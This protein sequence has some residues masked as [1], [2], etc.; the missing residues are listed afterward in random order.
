MF[1]TLSKTEFIIIAGNQP[2]LLLTQ[3]FLPYQ[4]QQIFIKTEIFITHVT[5]KQLFFFF[6]PFLTMFSTLTKKKKKKFLITG[7]S[8]F[9][10]FHN[11]FYPFK[12]PINIIPGNQHIF[13]YLTTVSP[14]ETDI[15]IIAKFFPFS[16]QMFSIWPSSFFCILIK[17]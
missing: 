15:I 8:I 17:I 9:S 4:R 7:T 1:S 16:L 6:F 12:K 3:C 13:L 10:F 14:N 2:F 5:N 11:V